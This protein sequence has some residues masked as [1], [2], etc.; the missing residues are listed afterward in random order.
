MNGAIGLMSEPGTNPGFLYQQ[1]PMRDAITAGLT[2]N[3]FNNHAE[4]VKMANI[5]QM[6]NV[7]TG[8][9]SHR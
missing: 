4:R 5:A 3:S 7:L 1:N 8:H 6:I 9:Y 2:L